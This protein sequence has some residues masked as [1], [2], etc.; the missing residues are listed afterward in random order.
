[1]SFKRRRMCAEF[2]FV[3]KFKKGIKKYLFA[4]SVGIT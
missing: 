1:M 3:E 2:E 4:Y